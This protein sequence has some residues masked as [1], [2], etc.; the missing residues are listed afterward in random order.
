MNSDLE[1]TNTQD[2]TSS[3]SQMRGAFHG[4]IQEQNV[5]QCS[6]LT[7]GRA[8]GFRWERNTETCMYHPD[9]D[10]P[11]AA[12]TKSMITEYLVVAVAEPYK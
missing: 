4:T 9:S 10:L 6:M 7:A 11:P 3:D 1:I 2:Q 8:W 12:T 5:P